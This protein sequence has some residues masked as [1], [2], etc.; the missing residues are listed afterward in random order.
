MLSHCLRPFYNQPTKSMLNSLPPSPATDGLHRP[1]S[2]PFFQLQKLQRLI[3]QSIPTSHGYSLSSWHSS[4][5]SYCS[6]GPEGPAVFA[7]TGI[8]HKMVSL[9]SHLIYP[10]T[11]RVVGAPQMISQPV[12]SIFPCSP[13]PSG[14]WP[15][16]GLSILWCCLP[17]SSSVCLAFFPLTLCLARFWSDLMN[18]KHVHTTSVCFIYI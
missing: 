10:L 6:E 8:W 13:L 7:D 15:T 16:P 5:S 12:S 17:T 11:V 3:C 1:G 14:T 4:S 9:S 18:G 2:S